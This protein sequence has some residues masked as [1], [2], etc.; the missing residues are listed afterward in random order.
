MYV[1]SPASLL[2]SPTVEACKPKRSDRGVDLFQRL[3][4]RDEATILLRRRRDGPAIEL[5]DKRAPFVRVV[6]L[7]TQQD[8]HCWAD[9]GV[10]GPGDVVKSD[11]IYPRAYHPK[12]GRLL[13]PF[14]HNYIFQCSADS[15]AVPSGP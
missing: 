15:A 9:I 6:I 8:E 13:S 1:A 2:L 5:L 10:I 12:P 3:G 4:E 14:V 7:E 11:L